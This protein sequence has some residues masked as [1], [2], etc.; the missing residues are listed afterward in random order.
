M[1]YLIFKQTIYTD[2]LQKQQGACTWENETHK[3]IIIMVNHIQ[4]Y[5]W[6]SIVLYDS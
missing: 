5:N 2:E 4:D 1:S 6:Y 3:L